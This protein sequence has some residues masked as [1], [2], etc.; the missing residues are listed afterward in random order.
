MIKLKVCSAETRNET[1]SS[2][3]TDKLLLPS[4]REEREAEGLAASIYQSQT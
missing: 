4:P 1:Y 3:E 2:P